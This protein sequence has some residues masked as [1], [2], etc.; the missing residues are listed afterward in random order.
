MWMSGAR[1]QGPRGMKQ[2]DRS[3]H[4][5]RGQLDQCSSSHSFFFSFY[6]LAV[7]PPF[8]FPLLV[9]PALARAIPAAIKSK[10]DVGQRDW[11]MA[12]SIFSLPK[13][14]QSAAF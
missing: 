5:V 9:N 8:P 10:G 6:S 12:T 2:I 1:R 7:F 11:P 14:H 3:A 13:Y 4:L